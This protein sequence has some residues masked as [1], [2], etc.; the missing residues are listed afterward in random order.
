MVSAARRRS[1]LPSSPNAAPPTTSPPHP[2]PRPILRGWPEKITRPLRNFPKIEDWILI[3]RKKAA[4][5]FRF[6]RLIRAKR[7]SL[8]SLYYKIGLFDYTVGLFLSALEPGRQ[9]TALH[10]THLREKREGGG[11]REV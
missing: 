9:A 1:S 6:L 11:E 7:R 3:N 2:L 10:G 4:K 5:G 8:C